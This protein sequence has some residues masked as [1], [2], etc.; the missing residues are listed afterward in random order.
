MS[1]SLHGTKP[2]SVFRL[3]GNDENSA[4]FALGWALEQS[5]HYRE[6]L[7][8]AVFGEV[9]DVNDVIITLQKH[10]EHGGYTDIELQDGHRFHAIVE[11]KRSWELPGVDQLKR[12]LPRLVSGGAERQRLIS[13]SAAN[14]AQAKRRLP[15]SL[16]GVGICHLSWGDLQRLARQ[17]GKRSSRF[18]ERLWLRQLAQHLQEFTS[19]ERQNDN[20]V[21]VVA[22]GK[23]PMV[24]GQTHTWIDVVEKDSL[25]YSTLA[26]CE[27]CSE[28]ARFRTVCTW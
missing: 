24:A 8:S 26:G 23:A 5:S 4:S 16:E 2:S 13:V 12:Y 25:S 6:L 15:A 11:A 14:Q 20:T 18:E 21:F 10:T 1:L 28:R 17:A 7:L 27:S 3:T 9:L 22:L 19:M